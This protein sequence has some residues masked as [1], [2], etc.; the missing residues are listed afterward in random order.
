MTDRNTDMRRIADQIAE[1]GLMA[2]AAD[3]V[4]A[5]LGSKSASGRQDTR[6]F[7]KQMY[8]AYRTYLGRIGKKPS[9]T[10]LLQF[11]IA[12]VGFGAEDAR[13][14]FQQTG[15]PDPIA[16]TESI[17]LELDG[18]KLQD[19]FTAAAQMGFE[20]NIVKIKGDDKGGYGI[21]HYGGGYRSDRSRAAPTGAKPAPEA[22]PHSSDSVDPTTDTVPKSDEAKK[23]NNKIDK[24]LMLR[25]AKQLGLEE[26]DIKDLNASVDSTSFQSLA[27]DPE[28]RPQLAIIGYA[29]L[30]ANGK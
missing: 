28:A 6:A 20:K 12:H 29:F 8:Q 19:L 10:N 13:E 25:I 17:I 16:K 11:L 26:E 14:L 3:S 1:A 18:S 22:K 24:K 15:I 30:K 4:A 7:A 23:V 2:K 9:E 5:G 27:N 21:N